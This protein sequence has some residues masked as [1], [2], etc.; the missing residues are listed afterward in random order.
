MLAL[1]FI[2]HSVTHHVSI[3]ALTLTLGTSLSSHEKQAVGGRATFPVWN[4]TRCHT[5]NAEPPQI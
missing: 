3:L 2:V 5:L 4:V 1:E